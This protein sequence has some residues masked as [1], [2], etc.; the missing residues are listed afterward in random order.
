VAGAGW[1]QE[2]AHELLGGPRLQFRDIKAAVRSAPGC[3]STP[4]SFDERVAETL[5]R[6]Y[7]AL[8]DFAALTDEAE[9]IEVGGHTAMALA[10]YAAINDRVLDAEIRQFLENEA[11]K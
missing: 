1:T 9:H 8:R 4:K 3:G 11:A 7:K 2:A 5:G 10:I 6:L